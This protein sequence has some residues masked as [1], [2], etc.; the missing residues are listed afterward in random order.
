[1]ANSDK[2]IL[3]TPG[4][5]TSSLPEIKFTGFNNDPIRLRVL[6]DNTISFEGSAGQLFSINNNLTTGNIFAV[7]DVS[8]VPSIF[9][10]ANGTV[11][12]AP[13]NGFVAIGQATAST[14][15]DIYGPNFIT[16]FTGNNKLG[17]AIRGS[18]STNDYSGID[19]YGYYGNQVDAS[20]VNQDRP[21]ARVASRFQG[22]GSY[23][24]LGTS[25][26]YATG[27]TNTALTINPSGWVGVGQDPISVM[28]IASSGGGPGNN[29]QLTLHQLGQSVINFGSYPANWNP[30]L[31]IQNITNTD[32]IWLSP[33]DDGYNARFRTGGCGLDFYIGGG[34]D[35]GA[36][37]LG[38]N[39]PALGQSGGNGHAHFYGPIRQ[40][41]TYDNGRHYSIYTYQN[42]AGGSFYVHMKTSI[43]YYNSYCMTMIQAWGYAYGNG[44]RID[45]S[46]NWYTYATGQGPYSVQYWT[47][48]TTY[49]MT[50]ST[51]Y[52]SSDGY[53]VIV[54]YTTGHYYI[55][56]TLDAL[57]VN[58]TPGGFDLQI[59]AATYS[60]SQTGV[61]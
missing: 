58:P 35:T 2:D 14:F 34:N 56:F 12:I 1:M 45:C 55:G 61:Y 37:M 38:L 25:N 26:S 39:T 42:T 7:S 40:R 9:A 29:R 30:A 33:I 8:G 18:K 46:W 11:G 15:L 20:F 27:I 44:G 4:K 24:T 22:D 52:Q 21:F 49:G 41:A 43:P 48:D 16:S 17:L 50:A 36:L 53:C 28:S 51:M 10:N 19:F 60:T 31:M 23:L 59:L 32:F 3:I 57:F 13:Y 5:D 6:D 54:G 47:D